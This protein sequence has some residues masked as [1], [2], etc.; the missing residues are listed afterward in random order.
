MAGELGTPKEIVE[1]H[2]YGTWK[3]PYIPSESMMVSN[4]REGEKDVGDIGCWKKRMPY[5]NDKDRAADRW[6][7][8]T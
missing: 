5:C 7:Y 2:P 1:S 3:V 6:R 4:S 8:S